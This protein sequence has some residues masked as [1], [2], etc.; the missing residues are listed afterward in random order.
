MNHHYPPK[1]TLRGGRSTH[2]RQV[3]EAQARGRQNA[4]A[5][6]RISDTTAGVFYGSVPTVKRGGTS[7]PVQ[8]YKITGIAADYLTAVTW[9]GT[10]PGTESVRIAKPPMI[11]RVDWHNITRDGITY[12]STNADGQSRTLGHSGTGED[13]AESEEVLYPSYAANDIIYADQPTGGTGVSAAPSWMDTNRSGRQF[14]APYKLRRVCVN[15]NWRYV[16]RREGEP[17]GDAS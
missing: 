12:T 6:T 17:F 13:D 3:V 14:H 4:S 7:T 5:F 9:D 1:P 15:G 11:R 10:T 2:D 16:M 8:C